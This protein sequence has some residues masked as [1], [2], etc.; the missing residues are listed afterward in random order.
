MV[1]PTTLNLLISFTHPFVIS[2]TPFP[3]LLLWRSVLYQRLETCLDQVWLIIIRKN[4]CLLYIWPSI[5]G[6]AHSKR[7]SKYT[8]YAQRKLRQATKSIFFNK[9]G[10]IFLLKN[11]YFVL[12]SEE[13]LETGSHIICCRQGNQICRHFDYFSELNPHKNLRLFNL[14]LSFLLEEVFL[15]LAFLRRASF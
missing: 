2:T 8:S 15:M 9:T 14:K 10:F 5:S 13:K 3:R 7:W 4:A 11:S 1:L 6:A 12:P